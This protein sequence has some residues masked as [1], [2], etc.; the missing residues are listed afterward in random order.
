MDQNV[1][2]FEEYLW[3]LPLDIDLNAYSS[4]IFVDNIY[5]PCYYNSEDAHDMWCKLRMSRYNYQWRILE[6][7]Y[8]WDTVWYCTNKG[9]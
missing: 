5:I 8:A 9:Y 1:A 3:T 2:N 4:E 6:V 7:E